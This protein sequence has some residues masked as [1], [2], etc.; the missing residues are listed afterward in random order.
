MKKGLMAV[1]FAVGTVRTVGF[2]VFG[3]DAEIAI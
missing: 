3:F 2:V 1:V